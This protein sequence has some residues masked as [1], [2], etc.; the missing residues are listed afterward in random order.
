MYDGCCLKVNS[1][2]VL[3]VV[4]EERVPVFLDIKKIICLR[5]MWLACGMLLVPQ[6]FERKYHAFAV[7]QRG[8]WLVVNPMQLADHTQQDVFTIAEQ[9]YVSLRYAV[10]GP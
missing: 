10:I 6:V 3:H 1:V 4:E 8:D 9:Q 7:D 2:Y 5:G